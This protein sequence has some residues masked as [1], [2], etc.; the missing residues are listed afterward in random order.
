MIVHLKVFFMA[1]LAMNLIIFWYESESLSIM[2][3]SHTAFRL[4]VYIS[5]NR[6]LRKKQHV[7]V[8]EEQCTVILLLLKIQIQLINVSCKS[9]SRLISHTPWRRACSA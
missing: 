8:A 3:T 5:I 7:Y 1:V 4:C 6:S 2:L 9:L